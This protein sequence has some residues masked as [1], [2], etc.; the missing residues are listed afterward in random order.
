MT[1]KSMFYLFSTYPTY[2][3]RGFE[4]CPGSWAQA[5]IDWGSIFVGAWSRAR[6]SWRPTAGDRHPVRLGCCGCAGL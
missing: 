2:G 3:N 6:G 5:N 1:K 4:G